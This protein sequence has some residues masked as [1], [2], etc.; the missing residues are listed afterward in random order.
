MN[1][2][3][4]HPFNHPEIGGFHGG[5]GYD[6]PMWGAVVGGVIAAQAASNAEQLA[7]AQSEA[8]AAIVAQAQAQ[9]FQQ[10]QIKPTIDA[11]LTA[12]SQIL[13]TPVPTPT[14]TAAAQMHILA[15]QQLLP[16][17]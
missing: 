5:V 11:H 16:Q 15:A 3:H 4:D 6:H 7:V 14:V 17:A 1:G 12:A 10:S 9:A 8:N 13:T 2:D